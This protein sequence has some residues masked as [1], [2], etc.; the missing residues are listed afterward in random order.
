MKVLTSRIVGALIAVS[1]LTTSCKK[2]LDI[3]Q[4]PNAAEQVDPKLLFSNA[5]LAYV[6]VRSSGDLYIPIALTAQAIASGGNNATTWGV[7]SAEQYN[8]NPLHMGNTWRAFY[9]Y[10]GA[11]LK[12]I[13]RL[14]E[15]AAV[16]NNN[17]SAQAKVLL[18]F[19][20]YDIT[21]LYGDAPFSEALRTDV[22]YPKF[23]T[24]PQIFE[25]ILAMMD[26]ALAQFDEAGPLKISDY[27]L[28]YKGDIAKWKRVARSLKLKT[29]MTMVD[30]D[31]SKAQAI[32][33][34]LAAG[35]FV[36]APSQNF[37]IGYFNSSGRY[38]PKYGLNKQFNNEQSFFGASKWVVNFMNP[39]NDPRLGIFFEKPA[40]AATFV[41]PEP[42]QDI[43]DAVHARVNRNYH[44]ANMPEVVFTYQEQLFFEAE[45]YARGLG[46]AVDMVKANQL[47]KKAVEESVKFH[48]NL[49]LQ[50]NLVTASGNSAAFTAAATTALASAA[51][52][53]AGLPDLSTFSSNREAVKYI[54]YHHWVDKWDRGID[55]FTQWRRSG[56]EGDEV[57]PITLPPGAP[58][59]GLFRRF[60]YPI[61]AEIAANPNAPKAK[62]EYFTKMWFDL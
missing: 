54:H 45:I 6:N 55:A 11:N 42:A 33:Q 50:A 51:T 60:E 25:G 14:A 31:P 29:L 41:A 2:Y 61:T 40:A 22:T 1:A 35:G 57:P 18:G 56:P 23:D 9:N 53:A 37:L 36:S 24:Q 27:D 20:Y 15:G 12:E 46:V 7:P 52:F 32:G 28:F 39:I 48:A 4:N 13:T 3:N 10:A 44:S 30:K 38:N 43:S 16:K 34:L 62:I 21:T 17:A 59:G 5:A 8:I 49:A 58:A 26:E 47:Y 19:V